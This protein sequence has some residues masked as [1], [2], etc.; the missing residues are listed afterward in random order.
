MEKEGKQET[1][2]RTTEEVQDLGPCM[3]SQ[4]DGAPCNCS[5]SDCQTCGKG[6]PLKK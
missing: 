6:V 4:G 2:K 1:G 3:E 5:D